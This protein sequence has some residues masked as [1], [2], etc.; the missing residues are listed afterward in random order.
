VGHPVHNFVK[1]FNIFDSGSIKI[2]CLTTYNVTAIKNDR[3]AALRLNN[4]ITHG[5]WV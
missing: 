5:I 2:I 1:I 3:E 4:K